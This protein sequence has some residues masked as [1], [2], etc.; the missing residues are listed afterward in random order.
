[1]TIVKTETIQAQ[2]TSLACCQIDNIS[3]S[4]DSC[5]S[6]M[7]DINGSTETAN[8]N[9][10]YHGQSWENS[11]YHFPKRDPVDVEFKDLRYTVRKFNFTK[12]KS[13]K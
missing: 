12:L 7:D 2:A 8:N 10:V 9:S 11:K 6:S 4:L 5:G 13:G 1:M 3:S